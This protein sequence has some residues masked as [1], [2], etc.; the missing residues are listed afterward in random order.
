MVKPGYD[1]SQAV[2]PPKLEIPAPEPVLPVSESEP[3]S[4]TLEPEATRSDRHRRV[5]SVILSPSPNT[6]TPLREGTPVDVALSLDDEDIL[7]PAHAQPTPYQN[8][9]S[10]PE[11]WSDLLGFL[12]S[13]KS[14][15]RLRVFDHPLAHASSYGQMSRTHL[16]SS[17]EP[18]RAHLHPTK[19]P[20]S[21]TTLVSQEWQEFR[22]LELTI[23]TRNTCSRIHT[24]EVDCETT[25]EWRSFVDR[26]TQI[27]N[28]RLSRNLLQDDDQCIA[29]ALPL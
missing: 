14:D 25:E 29:A 16:R 15:S 3:P 26:A 27:R 7:S 8:V 28:G 2:E 4:T 11:F 18:A 21:G 9:I 19:S 12:R 13:A 6:L 24:V 20:R 17:L 10:S 23:C 1:W 22:G 5:P